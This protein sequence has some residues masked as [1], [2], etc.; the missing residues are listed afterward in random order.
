M[1]DLQRGAHLETRQIATQL[2]ARGISDLGPLLLIRVATSRFP[3]TSLNCNEIG[4]D[5]STFLWRSWVR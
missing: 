5:T 4:L 2:E 1:L 3:S